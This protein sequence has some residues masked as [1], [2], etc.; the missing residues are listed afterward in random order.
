MI[1]EFRI[2]ALET[3]KTNA[4]TFQN[5]FFTIGEFNVFGSVY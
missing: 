1:F 3:F 2:C 5:P 4:F